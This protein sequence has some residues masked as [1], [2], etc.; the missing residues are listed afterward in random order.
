MLHFCAYE[1]NTGDFPTSEAFVG[2]ER[3]DKAIDRETT[4]LTH[5]STY[6]F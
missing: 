1:R 2:Q 4:S 5:L 6:S 3:I